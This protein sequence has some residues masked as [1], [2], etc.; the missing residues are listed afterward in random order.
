MY[1]VDDN[2]HTCA[3][4]EHFILAMAIKDSIIAECTSINCLYTVP[5]MYN[6]KTENVADVVSD[7]ILFNITITFLNTV[8]VYIKNK[9]TLIIV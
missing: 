8:L 1:G 6:I 2:K 3:A 7:L 9:K 5:Q 4:N